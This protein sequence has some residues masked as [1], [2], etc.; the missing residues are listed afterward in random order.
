MDVST[1]VL[2]GLLGVVMY[3]GILWSISLLKGEADIVDFGWASSVGLLGVWYSCVGTGDLITRI[4]LG[5]ASGVWGGR[6]AGYLLIKR[7]LKPGEDGRYKSLRASWGDSANR[8][9]FLFFQAQAILAFV[10]SMSF[11]VVAY[12]DG[13]EIRLLQFFGLLISLLSIT[14]ES[15]ADLQLSRFVS[16]PANKG[17]VCKVGLWRYSRHPNYF[18]E[19]LGWCAY[20][21]LGWGSPIW[22]ISL[23]SPSCILYLILKVTGIPPTEERSLQSRPEEYKEY[24]RTTSSFVPWVPKKGEV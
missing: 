10:L 9:F 15:L 16:N 17:R 6:L 7:V 18:F 4:F 8:K 12:H 11:L 23:F 1:V 19:W 2:I 14:G 5:L 22:W 3:M 20:P 13:S 21:L 24:Q